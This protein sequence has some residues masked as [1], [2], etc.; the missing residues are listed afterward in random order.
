MSTTGTK[1]FSVPDTHPYN[2]LESGGVDRL[3]PIVDHLWH[4]EFCVSIG[5]P[6]KVT[7]NG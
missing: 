7:W 2:D 5:L 6:I 4:D 1:L 3:P